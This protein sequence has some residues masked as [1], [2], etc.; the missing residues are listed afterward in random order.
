[1]KKKPVV[2]IAKYGEFSLIDR[3]ANILPKIN[4]PNLLLDIGDDTAVIKIDQQR[5]LLLTCDIQIE[6]QHFRLDYMTPY[7]VGRRAIAVNLS[8]IAAMGGTPIYA[9]VSLGLP[10]SLIVEDYDALFEGMRDE[11]YPHQAAIVGGNLAQNADRLIVDI[12][13]IGEVNLP[14]LLTREGAKVGDRI[15]VSGKIGASGAGFQI[16]QKYGRSYPEKYQAE[17]EAHMLPTARVELGKQLARIDEITAMIDLSDGLAGDLYHICERSGVGAEIYQD[18]LPVTENLQEISQLT[19]KPA[20]EIALHSGEDYELVFTANPGI[21]ND[22]IET[23]SQSVEIPLT[24]IGRI[25]SSFEGYHMVNSRGERTR[26]RPKGW[27]HFTA[28]EK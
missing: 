28:V 7:Q 26:L 24:E 6:G 13:L 20:L 12:T 19:A 23:L 17:V 4:D 16:L 25:L 1:V 22:T 14:H 11:L 2:S 21:S 27:D 18:R 8:D 5:A 10:K 15:F 9:L 3:I